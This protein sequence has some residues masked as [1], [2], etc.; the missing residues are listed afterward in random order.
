MIGTRMGGYM[1]GVYERVY[2]RGMRKR[3]RPTS[4]LPMRCV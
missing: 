2:E 3:E 1:R 4:M